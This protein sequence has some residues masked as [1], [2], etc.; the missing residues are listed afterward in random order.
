MLGVRLR[1]IEELDCGG[2]PADLRLEHFSVVFQ[3][4]AVKGKA[5]GKGKEP[6][7]I[8]KC[9]AELVHNGKSKV[10]IIFRITDPS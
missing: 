8:L 2:V 10:T 5:W 1:E 9:T 4:P 7:S 6:I 3:I